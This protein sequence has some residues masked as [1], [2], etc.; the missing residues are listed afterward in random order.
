MDQ[1]APDIAKETG[2]AA[3]DSP[4]KGAAVY[5][6][7]YAMVFS[8]VNAVRVFTGP[9]GSVIFVF[10]VEFRE[11]IR[12]RQACY[13]DLQKVIEIIQ[14][15]DTLPCDQTSGYIGY[16]CAVIFFHKLFMP[17]RTL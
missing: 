11:T 10:A 12:V 3:C 13:F 8:A 7:I 15:S 5:A 16:A 14:G 9:S 4:Q 6:E 17:I 1:V 2:L